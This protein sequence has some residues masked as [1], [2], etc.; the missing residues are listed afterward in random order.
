MRSQVRLVAVLAV[1]LI[2]Y[3]LLIRAFHFM[4]QPTDRGWYG[5]L[6]LILGLILLV[7]V[8]IREVWR[9]L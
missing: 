9:N 1:A 8:I 6:A 7:P 2:A 5:G 4:S 3:G